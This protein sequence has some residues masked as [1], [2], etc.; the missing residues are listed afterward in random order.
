MK[1]LIII[2]MISLVLLMSEYLLNT[3]S[4]YILLLNIKNNFLQLNLSF[5]IKFMLAAL[6]GI[7]ITFLTINECVKRNST[8]KLVKRES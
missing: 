5:T 8:I 1:K 6:G 4:F 3:S 2:Y 7:I